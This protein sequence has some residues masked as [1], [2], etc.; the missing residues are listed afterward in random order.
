MGWNNWAIQANGPHIPFFFSKLC[1]QMF[2]P[3]KAPPLQLHPLLNGLGRGRGEDARSGSKTGWGSQRGRGSAGGENS[4]GVLK[5]IQSRPKDLQRQGGKCKMW[6]R[7]KPKALQQQPIVCHPE[8]DV[9]AL[10]EGVPPLARGHVTV[11]GHSAAAETVL[12]ADGSCDRDGQRTSTWRWTIKWALLLYLRWVW[13][14][15]RRWGGLW[16]C[17][18]GFKITRFG[19]LRR[20][21]GIW[22][23]LFCVVLKTQK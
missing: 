19:G 12:S 1:L 11:L 7:M 20:G 23:R 9:T 5:W 2:P 18:C 14:L 17:C 15:R 13:L 8:P 21:T 4:A 10:E 3:L 22:G 16:Q 6:L